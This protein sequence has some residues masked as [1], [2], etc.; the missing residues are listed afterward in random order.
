MKDLR[1]II[2]SFLF[3]IICQANA[4]A[5]ETTTITNPTKTEPLDEVIVES[6]LGWIG[7]KGMEA[8]MAGDFE[9]AEIIFEKEF[10]VL[11]RSNN[12]LYN[13]A[14][15]ASLS[16]SRANLT[17]QSFNATSP[18]LNGQN[19]LS[20]SSSAEANLAGNS[21]RRR[22]VG[23][24]L[25]NDNVLTDQD[26]AFT[27]YMSG[28]S[29]LKLGK[30]DEAEKSLEASLHYDKGNTD[31]RMRIG[32]LHLRK[33]NIKKAAHHLEK[34]EKRRVKCKK[35]DCD[36]YQ[37]ILNSASTLAVQISKKIHDTAPKGK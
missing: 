34:L 22:K 30:Y 12:G 10:I 17:N 14:V 13:S 9:A 19:S 16:I 1:T 2:A 15:D 11:R 7:H 37:E 18:N 36:D 20:N 21:T 29:E 25:L 33:N 28:L 31:A 6:R 8:F 24:N 26:F 5:Q 32:L 27:K 3:A 35:I 4:N 23:K